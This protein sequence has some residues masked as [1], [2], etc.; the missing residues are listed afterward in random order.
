MTC[1]EFHVN[2]KTNN[3]Q[4]SI[5][6]LR[7]L[8]NEIHPYSI[9]STMVRSLNENNMSS[10]TTIC[11]KKKRIQINLYPYFLLEVQKQEKNYFNADYSRSSSKY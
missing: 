10:L 11:I 5:D 1:L 2:P 9:F 3:N 6:S 4:F 8:K 7:L